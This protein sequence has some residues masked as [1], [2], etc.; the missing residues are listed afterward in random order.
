MG[1]ALESCCGESAAKDYG[2]GKDG[3]RLGGGAGAAG[4]GGGGGGGGGR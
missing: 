2:T 1:N 4:S 3:V